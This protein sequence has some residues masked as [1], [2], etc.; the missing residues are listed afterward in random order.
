MAWMKG[1][2]RKSGWATQSPRTSRRRAGA[3]EPLRRR[4]VAAAHGGVQPLPP[5]QA[6]SFEVG[7]HQVVL[8]LEM[9]VEGGLGG[10]GLRDHGVDTSR[11]DAALIEQPAGNAEDPGPLE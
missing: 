11:V 4:F 1:Q 7:G 10:T 8:G 9:T 6:A 3:Q 5:E 2:R